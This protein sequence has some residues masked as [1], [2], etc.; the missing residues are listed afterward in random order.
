MCVGMQ[1]I[2]KYKYYVASDESQPP[3][4]LALVLVSNVI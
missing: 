2:R 1:V 4:R 3:K